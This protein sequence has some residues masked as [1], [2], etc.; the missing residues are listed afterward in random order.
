MLPLSPTSTLNP[1]NVHGGTFTTD[2][3]G[4]VAN[5]GNMQFGATGG[6]AAALRGGNLY[7]ISGSGGSPS[8]V[9][10]RPDARGWPPRDS[11]A[12]AGTDPPP[13]DHPWHWV[14]PSGK[15]DRRRHGQSDR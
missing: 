1:N 15:T 4:G 11:Q 13:R 3:T 8:A 7:S 5:A 12:T 10:R 9:Q 2:Q 14:D 6:S